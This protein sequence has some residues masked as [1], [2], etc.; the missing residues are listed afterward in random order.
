MFSQ[1]PE[2]GIVMAKSGSRFELFIIMTGNT[3]HPQ[4]SLVSI[5]V[6][7]LAFQPQSKVGVIS[8]TQFR[9]P[10]EFLFMTLAAIY[11]AMG[12]L[13]GVSCERVIEKVFIE[14]DHFKFP[15]MVVIVARCT[16]LR[17]HFRGNVIPPVFIDPR[18]DLF[19][20]IK[21][22]FVGNL[23][24]QNMAFDT[25]GHPLQMCMGL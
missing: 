12:P 3:V 6:A 10:D 25:I 13:K 4:G 5:F 16:L 17:F 15:S 1:Q 7:V 18:S 22:L 23:F 2:G 24:S 8:F 14:T 21:A 20:A 11:P 19:V 9:I